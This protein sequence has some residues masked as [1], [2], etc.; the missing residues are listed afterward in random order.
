MS[1]THSKHWED[2]KYGQERVRRKTLCNCEDCK[3]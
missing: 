1:Y 2:A 3:I